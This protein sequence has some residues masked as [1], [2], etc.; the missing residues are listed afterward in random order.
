[1]YS[2]PNC[3]EGNDFG[4]LLDVGRH[5]S[6]T[7]IPQCWFGTYAIREFGNTQTTN[8]TIRRHVMFI[9]ATYYIQALRV[10]AMI[11]PEIA[12]LFRRLDLIV[13][14]SVPMV[15]PRIGQQI[16]GFDDV[17]ES[18]DHALVRYLAPFNLTGLP[19]LSIPC[20]FSSNGLPIG[21]Q[22]IGKAY[23][24]ATV[25]AVGQ[26]IEQATDWHLRSPEI[27]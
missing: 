10:R 21:M 8:Q 4:A 17:E 13:A 24:E 15:A 1:M 25:L 23:D 5:F 2:L 7:G 14:P 3:C 22:I 6:P 18:V 9:P 11:Y 16:V 20:G 26:A 19:A 12:N 27:A